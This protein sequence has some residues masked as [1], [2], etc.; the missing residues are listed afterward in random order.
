MIHLTRCLIFLL[1]L[2]LP[3]AAS[4]EERVYLQA[5]EFI[6][7]VFGTTAIQQNVLW[8][9]PALRATAN[10][11]LG[12]EPSQLRQKYWSDGKRSAWILS[13]IGKEEQ[14]TAGF[15]VSAGHIE[16]ARILVYRESRGDEIRYPAFLAQLKGAS[17]D[18]D[19]FLTR[20]V[21]GISGATLSV[22]AMIRMAR[23]ALYFASM[24]ESK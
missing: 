21:D 12:H 20:H 16:Q 24:A 6:A 3:W 14:I 11:I 8:V 9:T 4:A 15:V 7:S 23:L 22:N 19:H 1:A 17:L 18:D 2:L 13:E 10:D 5:D